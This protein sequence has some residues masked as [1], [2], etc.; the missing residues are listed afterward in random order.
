MTA[1]VLITYWIAAAFSMQL[2]DGSILHKSGHGV[3]TFPSI[4]ECKKIL[5]TAKAEIERHAADY[6]ASNGTDIKIEIVEC[7]PSGQDS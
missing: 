2:A 3:A 6:N 1:I 5:P 7:V 4:E